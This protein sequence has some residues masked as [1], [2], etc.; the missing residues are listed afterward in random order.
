LWLFNRF[1][2][3]VLVYDSLS[4]PSFCLWLCILWKPSHRFFLGL[5]Y[6]LCERPHRAIEAIRDEAIIYR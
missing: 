2:S 6:R 5:F 1:N 3:Q 4:S